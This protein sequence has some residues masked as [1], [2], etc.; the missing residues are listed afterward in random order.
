MIRQRVVFRKHDLL[1]DPYGQ[2]FDLIICRN[3]AIYFSDEAKRKINQNFCSSLKKNGILFSGG[4]E[5]MLN[6]EEIGFQRLCPCFYRKSTSAL[7]KAS[8]MM[9]TFSRT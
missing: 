8:V 3:V 7:N 2:A 1:H 5:T 4:T 6:A 9:P